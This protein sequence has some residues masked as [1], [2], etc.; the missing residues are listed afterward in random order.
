VA[1]DQTRDPNAED[2]E[3]TAVTEEIG[4]ELRARSIPRSPPVM[5]VFPDSSETSVIR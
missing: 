4:E 1:G 2:T 3:V 5:K